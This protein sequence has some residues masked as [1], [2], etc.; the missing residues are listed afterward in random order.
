MCVITARQG[1]L[2]LHIICCVMFSQNCSAAGYLRSF[3][4][5]VRLAAASLVFKKRFIHQLVVVRETSNYRNSPEGK[6]DDRNSPRLKQ[7][8]PKFRS[9]MHFSAAEQSQHDK[10]GFQGRSNCSLHSSRLT[11]LQSTAAGLHQST[12]LPCLDRYYYLSPKLVK[13]W[14]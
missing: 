11:V 4:V 10:Y 3:C 5:N 13:P 14:S 1:K 2:Y 7:Q 6:D 12:R 9:Y 8:S